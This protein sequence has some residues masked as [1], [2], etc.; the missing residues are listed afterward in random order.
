[1]NKILFIMEDFGFFFFFFEKFEKIL[2][3]FVSAI[4]HN[5]TTPLIYTYS[6]K[7][8]SP[9]P[10]PTTSTTTTII[11]T[12]IFLYNMNIRSKILI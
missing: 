6:F 8:H 12:T 2:D 9:T 11:T 10:P 4:L 5:T 1:M 7:Y 3:I